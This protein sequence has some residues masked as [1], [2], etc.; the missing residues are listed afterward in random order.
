MK[1]TQRLR[2]TVVLG[3]MTAWIGLTAGAFSVDAQTFF[4]RVLGN[5]RTSFTARSMALGGTGVATSYS[6]SAMMTNPALLWQALT[7]A[8]EA[9]HV[10]YA[11]VSAV[12]SRPS[13]NRVFPL[14][15]TFGG[16]QVDN[17]YVTN[18]PVF[19]YADFGLVYK[20]NRNLYLGLGSYE[21]WTLD[22]S[23]KERLAAQLPSS[24]V[25]RDRFLDNN[26]I[27]SKG[28]WRTISASAA[29][30]HENK[31]SVGA[32]VHWLRPGSLRDHYRYVRIND[33]YTATTDTIGF[34]RSYGGRSSVATILGLAYEVSPHLSIA[35]AIE[36]PFSIR[37]KD[38]NFFT[39]TDTA[40]GLPIMAW[41]TTYVG[42]TQVFRN[43]DVTFKNPFR[44]SFGV[45][46]RPQNDLFSRVTLELNY[47]DWSSYEQTFSENVRAFGRSVR[48]YSP[49]F[50]NTWDFRIGV[51]HMFFDYTP[52]RF[53]FAHIG[54]P[55]GDAY[56]TSV[57]D[58]GTG[59]QRGPFKFDIAAELANR[60]YRYSILFLQPRL[61]R[62]EFDRVDES[63]VR[64]QAT[65]SYQF[66]Y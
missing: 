62:I 18:S 33:A 29:W 65:L 41:D 6:A 64:F 22:Y 60:D 23:Y 61:S 49:D 38:N 19:G 8:A 1:H 11:D 34:D 35:A 2:L 54:S 5:R 47:T 15:D 25:N 16:F 58:F 4:D 27:D 36:S 43:P 31:I 37:S 66:G 13:E 40:T 52:V 39:A 28:S 30:R 42:S 56:V 59:F 26:I 10:A 32:T 63:T 55:L 3:L 45:E 44:F 12:A 24:S 53:G 48:G 50:N 57:F 9:N 7:E 21:Y 20:F 51:E 14:L 17:V 46:Y